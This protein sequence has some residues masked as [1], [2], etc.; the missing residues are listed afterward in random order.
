MSLLPEAVSEM[1]NNT[2]QHDEP[3]ESAPDGALFLLGCSDDL[4]RI[5]GVGSVEL[6]LVQDVLVVN[7]NV[8]FAERAVHG[9]RRS[10]YC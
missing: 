3:G 9:G 7:V 1:V 5:A 8:Y 2:V 4:G 10:R 6:L